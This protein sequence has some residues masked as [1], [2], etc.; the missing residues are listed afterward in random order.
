MDDSFKNIDELLKQS[1]EGY[2]K[3]PSAGV[4]KRISFKLALIER[5]IYF[6]L[7]ALFIVVVTG[8]FFYF[9]NNSEVET[10]SDNE[11]ISTIVSEEN[12]LALE[13]ENID[14]QIESNVNI[15]PVANT[16]NEIK[17]EKTKEIEVQNVR[18]ESEVLS[19]DNAADIF[20]S[21]VVEN[22]EDA[23][24][25][26][27]N[28][29]Y[30]YN[31]YPGLER[32]NNMD[33]TK[34]PEA[35]SFSGLYLP[36]KYS[37][38][39]YSRA[40]Y[41]RMPSVAID[42]YGR[43]G[44]LWSYGVH[45]TPEIIFTNDKNNSK[46]MALNLDVSGIYNVNDWCIEVGAGVGLSEDNGT[47]RIDY[48]QYDSI[49]YYYEVTGFTINPETGKPE[50]KTEI[51]GVYDTVLY[52]Q[53]QTTDNLYTYLRFP[54]FGGL[55]VHENKNFSVCIKAGGIY[56][57]LINKNEPGTDFTNDNATWIN[58]SNETPERIQS[59]LQLSLAVGLHYR[60][61]NKLSISAEPIY[62]YYVNP[63][64]ERR[65][66]LKSPWSVGLRAGILFKF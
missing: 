36:N 14:E 63:V 48:A 54:V 55:N 43:R 62:N 6:I 64:Y 47:Y 11:N 46:K 42:D 22:N 19:K 23:G 61:S 5:G 50:Y 21:S 1:L 41:V 66:N 16:D 17:S 10:N 37:T 31:V 58:I 52:N 51:E 18:E 25:L 2:K 29:N 44:G 38:T 20:L 28:K 60:L 35:I 12:N 3:E 4:W 59:H 56:S 30:N 7:S 49:G 33:K 8:A 40:S 32:L 65:Y 34:S 39:I 45:I 13:Q 9:N 27:E 53:T 24:E 15:K 26:S 57:I